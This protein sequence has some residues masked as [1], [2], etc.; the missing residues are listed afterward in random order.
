MTLIEEGA[1]SDVVLKLGSFRCFCFVAAGLGSAAV[2][3]A[4]AAV[5]AS[6]TAN[7]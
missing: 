4:K 7:I 1:Y 3:G 6:F 5:I 2:G